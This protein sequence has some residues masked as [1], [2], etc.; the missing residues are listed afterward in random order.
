VW[1]QCC[2]PIGRRQPV[3][4]AVMPAQP[5]VKRHMDLNWKWQTMR[6]TMDFVAVVVADDVA[7]G[8]TEGA[9]R[10]PFG[11]FGP[12]NSRLALVPADCSPKSNP[13]VKGGLF[14]GA[15]DLEYIF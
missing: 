13:G 6:T 7:E 5:M 1:P 10:Q 2:W 12:P 15:L 14:D 3:P 9:M 4:L 8:R 11:S